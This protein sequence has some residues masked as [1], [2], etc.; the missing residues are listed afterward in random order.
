MEIFKSFNRLR[1]MRSQKE[2]PWTFVKR[3]ILKLQYEIEHF[4]NPLTS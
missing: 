4:L 2:K 1:G 3:I